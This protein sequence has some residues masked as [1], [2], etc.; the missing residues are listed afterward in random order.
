M[1]ASPEF[2]NNNNENIENI[3]KKM[4]NCDINNKEDEN[5]EIGENIADG[6]LGLEKDKNED[7]KEENK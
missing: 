2:I 6:E 4:E 5:N 1:V 3:E 7:E